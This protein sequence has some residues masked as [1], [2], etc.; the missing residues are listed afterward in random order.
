MFLLSKEGLMM[1]MTISVLT[2][3]THVSS[4]G[5][6][7]AILQSSL[8]TTTTVIGIVHVVNPYEEF[9]LPRERFDELIAEGKIRLHTATD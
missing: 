5:S 8:C 7:R 3:F 9:S 6:H 4:D 1:Q 2:S